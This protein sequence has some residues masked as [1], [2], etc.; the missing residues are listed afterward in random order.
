LIGGVTASVWERVFTT[1]FYPALR[2]QGAKVG[3]A[4]DFQVVDGLPTE[5]HDVPLDKIVTPEGVIIP[6]RR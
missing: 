5:E 6:E 3:V 1:A 2:G 4:Y